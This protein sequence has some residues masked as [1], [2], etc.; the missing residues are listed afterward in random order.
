MNPTTIARRLRR[1]Q[2][3][4]QKELWRALKAGRFAGFKF[5]RQH[6]CGKYFLDFY[7]PIAR[8]SIPTVATLLHT[9]YSNHLQTCPIPENLLPSPAK[10]AMHASY[11]RR[12]ATKVKGGRVQRKN[13]QIPTGRLGCVID[14][15]SPGRGFR[16]VL[17]KRDLQ[18][19]IDIIP[20]WDRLAERLERITLSAH[21][22]S[23]YGAHGFF[24]REETC[25]ILLHA[26]NEDLWVWLTPK[27]FADHRDIFLAL[28]VSHEESE[29]DILCRFTEAQARAFMLL[30]VFMHELGHHHHC[31][32]AK[33]RST[34]LDEDYAER[35]ANQRFHQMLPDYKRVFGDPTKGA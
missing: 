5:R 14:R 29:E 32:R 28:G 16:H 13:R 3:D 12:T 7:C 23:A 17:T 21:S 30:H 11:N 10:P 31:L 25:E 22:S 24:H 34:D 15:E 18:A 6:P 8:N 1:N 9:N 4:E 33:H 27:F 20:D 2:T 19:F 35:F 26:W